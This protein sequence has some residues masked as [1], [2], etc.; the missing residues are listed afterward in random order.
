MGEAIGVYCVVV[1]VI[2]WAWVF[3]AGVCEWISCKK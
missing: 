1:Q 3:Y 2:G